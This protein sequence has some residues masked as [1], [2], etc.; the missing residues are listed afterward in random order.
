MKNFSELLATETVIPVSVAI[1]PITYNGDPHAWIVINGL[2]V[3]RNSLSFP[4]S[5]T[6]DIP[7]LEPIDIEIGMSDKIYNEQAETAVIIKSICIDNF[8]IVP[9]YTQWAQYQ[10]ERDFN[11]PTSYLGFNG[12]WRLSTAEP[13]YQWHHRITGQGWLLEPVLQKNNTFI[14]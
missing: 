14:S 13:F 2:T 7:L 6:V 1:E 11:S 3:Y 8:E 12:T 5:V 9:N 4:I 10:N